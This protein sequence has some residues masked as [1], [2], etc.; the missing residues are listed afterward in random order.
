MIFHRLIRFF[1][2]IHEA[3]QV[4]SWSINPSSNRRG[5]QPNQSSTISENDIE[6]LSTGINLLVDR[7]SLF[8]TFGAATIATS[9]PMP[10]K[11]AAIASSPVAKIPEWTLDGGVQMPVLALNTVGLSVEDTERAITLSTRYGMTHVDFHPGKERDGVAQ[12]LAKGGNRSG[13]FLNTKIRKAPPGTS[14][15]DAAERTRKQIEEDLAAL[16]LKSVDMLML[17]DSPDAEVIQAQWAVLEDA[18]AAGQTR[19]IGVINFCEFS[20][21]SVLTTAKVTPALNYYLTHVGM[22]TDPRGLRSFGESRGIRTF[23]Y[24]AAGEPGPNQELLNNPVVN[25]IAKAHNVSPEAVALRWLLQTGA[26]VSVRPTLDFGLGTSVCTVDNTQCEEG[27]QARASSFSW[28]LT[29][30]E[31]A[32]LNA[33][34]SPNDNPTLFSSAGCPN[35]FV[36][37][38]KK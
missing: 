34:T 14:P 18:L 24:G 9:L 38:A 21:K 2:L 35:A 20:L 32:K 3:T 19:S 27:L 31:M 13:L 36:M 37:P 28:Q 26:A 4:L 1:C 10:A 5:F 33:L 6:T 15:A 30:A 29:K 12:Y 11:S 23:A 16:N 8:A 25:R 7:R 17:R 22:G